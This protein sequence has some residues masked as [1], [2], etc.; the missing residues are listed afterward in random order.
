MKSIWLFYTT[1]IMSLACAGD[2]SGVEAE[3]TGM[4][5]ALFALGFVGILILFISSRQLSGTEKVYKHIIEKQKEIEHKQNLF[6]SNITENIH[7]IV[8]HT[9]KE[10][11]GQ[12]KECFPETMVEK[13]KQ[14]LNVTGDLIE[15]LRLKSKKVQVIN[16]QFNLN[17][18]LNEVAGS[19]SSKFHGS[20]VDLIF[21]IDNNIPRYLI[22]DAL[23]L[24]KSLHNLLAYVLRT[25]PAGKV[26]LSIGMFGNY[27]ER[28]ELQFRL[29]DT[30][31]GLEKEALD[32]L[33]IPVYDEVQKQYSGLGL[34][35][36]KELIGL[37]G[38]EI[39][40]QS[41]IGKGTVFSITLPLG[42]F[43]PD[44]RR[45]YRLPQKELTAKKVFIVDHDYDSA[46]AVKKMFAYFKHDVK[47]MEKEVFLQKKVDLGVYDIVILDQ[48]IFAYK[49]IY[50]YLEQIKAKQKLKLVGLENLLQ[51]S[52]EKKRYAVIDRY[53]SK[54]LSQERVFELIVNLYAPEPVKTPVSQNITVP[55]DKIAI[56]SGHI[57]E[58]PNITQQHFAEFKGKRL[59]IV[60]DDEINQ[61]V[62]SNVLKFSGI[63]ITF[64]NN[65]RIAVNTVVESDKMFD[66]VLMDIN[67]P[68]L[69]GYAA[70]QMIRKKSAYDKLPI[71]AFTAL[72]LESEKEKIFKSGMNAYLTKPL[73]I[74]KLYNVFHMYMPVKKGTESASEVKKTKSAYTGRVEILDI[75]K[76]ITYSNNNEGF[77]IEIL[78]EFRDAYGESAEL[79]AKLVHEHRYEQVKMLC[80]DMKGLTGTIGAGEMYMLVMKIHHKVLYRQEEMLSEYVAVYKTTL[81]RLKEEI[82]AYLGS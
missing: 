10:V 78:R 51:R 81:E 60:E 73:N 59:L 79:F 50:N 5:I 47:I 69:D 33:F 3:N 80:L 18:V 54:P 30:G 56:H 7:E 62:L 40:V 71:V 43:E 27:A 21:D 75:K 14:L 42:I 36:A 23:H 49:K 48:S 66:M 68:V 46:L 67:M 55:D 24:E 1:G 63:E 77:Y 29:S 26:V 19:V 32:K 35:V 20:K 22:G 15:F 6:L 61:K 31:N 41:S 52:E 2:L 8:E 82:A 12:Q 65:G 76:G 13:E 74:G 4:W 25:V 64:A 58:A 45:N 44:N 70:T 72:A 16:E 11:M 28:V 37:M 57:H 38:G 53:L 34:F 39:S 17:N 9:Y